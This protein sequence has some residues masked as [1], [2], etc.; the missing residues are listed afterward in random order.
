MKSQKDLYEDHI[1]ELV[2]G[3][4]KENKQKIKKLGLDKKRLTE[5]VHDGI[6]YQ[7]FLQGRK[8]RTIRFLGMEFSRKVKF[9]DPS[10]FQKPLELKR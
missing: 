6:T 5:I 4:I 1:N 9:S 7:E 3:L 2:I 8:I 10:N